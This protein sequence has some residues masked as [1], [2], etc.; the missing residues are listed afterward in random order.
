MALT[1]LP[2]SDYPFDMFKSFCSYSISR[3]LY[4]AKWD[5]NICVLGKI[6]SRRSR[7]SVYL[8]QIQLKS[9]KE[10]SERSCIWLQGLSIFSLSKILPLGFGTLPTVFIFRFPKQNI[11]IYI[12]HSILWS[13]VELIILI[14]GK[15]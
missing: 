7:S 15:M 14:C 2:T 4:L 10:Q 12:S 9:I 1:V 13:N 3:C 11:C 8:I 6:C 5:V